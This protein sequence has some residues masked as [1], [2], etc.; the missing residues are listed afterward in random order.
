MSLLYSASLVLLSMVVLVISLL[1]SAV[2]GVIYRCQTEK[3]GLRQKCSNRTEQQSKTESTNDQ[4]RLI[5]ASPSIAS[6]VE[7]T[8]RSY[9]TFE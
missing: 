8:K 6:P 1:V 2:V 4:A 7:P 5:A 3:R 9:D